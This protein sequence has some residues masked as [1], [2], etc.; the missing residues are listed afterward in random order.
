[1]VT[2]IAVAGLGSIGRRHA[3][4]LAGRQDVAVELFDPEAG[5]VAA[6]LADLGGTETTVHGTWKDLLAASPDAVVI[7]SPHRFHVDQTIEAL[8]AGCHVLCEKPVS[9]RLEDARRLL[10]VAR[11][12]DRVLTYGYHLRFHPGLGRLK[13][14]VEAGAFG[15]LLSLH[16]HVGSYQTLLN[17]VSGYQAGTEGA[18]LLDYVHQPDAIAWLSGRRPVAVFA[19]GLG[20]GHR[21]PTS[22]PDL[23]SVQLLYDGDFAG[24]Y[25][26]NYLQHPEIHRYGLIG[27]EGYAE[28][29]LNAGTL[30]CAS[31]DGRADE[32]FSTERDPVYVAEHDAFLAALAGDRPP[33]SPLED[34]IRSLEVQEAALRSLRTGEKIGLAAG[35]PRTCD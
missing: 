17:S 30:V 14:L 18:L 21:Q 16:A 11:S 24:S 31:A 35:Q 25:H 9:D 29:D 10:A 19:A 1:M 32:R 4:L 12:S 33:I 2:S 27:S 34:A 22:S 28:L 20:G 7:A 23:I 15:R 26:L 8:V 13:A 6:A 3:R 5:Q